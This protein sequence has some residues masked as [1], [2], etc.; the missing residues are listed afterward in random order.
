MLIHGAYWI[1]ESWEMVV[2]ARK[3]EGR[4]ERAY[5]EGREKE[6]WKKKGYQVVENTILIQ[7]IKMFVTFKLCEGTCNV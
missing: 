4:K 1:S 5:K 7:P 3:K 2:A 6:G